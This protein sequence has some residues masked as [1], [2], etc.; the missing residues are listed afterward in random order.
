MMARR[1]RATPK[2][3]NPVAHTP[4]AY[5]FKSPAPQ[6]LHVARQSAETRPEIRP[7]LCF[8]ARRR[9]PCRAPTNPQRAT[10]PKLILKPAPPIPLPLANSQA[11]RDPIELHRVHA[12]ELPPSESPVSWWSD[13]RLDKQGQ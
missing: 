7:A 6:L 8:R 4:R 5:L 9:M 1:T 10:P 3:R 11:F 13:R 12:T 2:W